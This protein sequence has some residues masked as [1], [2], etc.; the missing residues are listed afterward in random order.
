MSDAVAIEMQEP[1]LGRWSLKYCGV[2]SLGKSNG[3][4]EWDESR[5]FMMALI[6]R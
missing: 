4:I 6:E 2:E 1:T 5:P 3:K